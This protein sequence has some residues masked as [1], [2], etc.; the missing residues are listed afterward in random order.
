MSMYFTVVDIVYKPNVFAC[1]LEVRINGIYTL[2]YQPHQAYCGSR[3]FYANIINLHCINCYK[4]YEQ[5]TP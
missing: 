5:E 1:S 2:Y 3:F 4:G